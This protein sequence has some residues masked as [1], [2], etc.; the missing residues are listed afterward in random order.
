MRNWLLIPTKEQWNKWSLPSKLTFA[1]TF[2]GV[3][4]LLLTGLFFVL[5]L[6]F[7]SDP[8]EKRLDGA[9]LAAIEDAKS[10]R[11]QLSSLKQM[12]EL[13]SKGNDIAV[14]SSKD[15]PAIVES[16]A[17]KQLMDDGDFYQRLSPLLRERLPKFIQI[18]NALLNGLG[19]AQPDITQPGT[20]R[21]L[22][23]EL[24]TET[25]CLILER[26]LRS[27]EMTKDLHDELFNAALE[28]QVLRMRPP[29]P[30]DR[31]NLPGHTPGPSAESQ[32]KD[33]PG[34]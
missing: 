7:A 28:L 33:L 26:Q 18:R 13:K 29:A 19:R 34:Q 17:M 31:G 11:S 32:V 6:I 9:L 24:E 27:G 12:G 15:G 16:S 23:I 25:N 5:P 22:D 4:S 20:L 21:L 1:G 10:I 2:V 3:L 14:P 30:G 8:T